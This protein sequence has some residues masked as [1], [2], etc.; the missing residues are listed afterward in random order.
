MASARMTAS[1]SGSWPSSGPSPG[2]GLQVWCCPWRR[3][4]WGLW[5][6]AGWGARCKLQD[7]PVGRRACR[8]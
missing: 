4:S 8:V 5:G 7:E 6:L 2:E 3:P 1:V